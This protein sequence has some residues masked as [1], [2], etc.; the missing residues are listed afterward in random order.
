MIRRLL[1]SSAA[2]AP[3]LVAAAA[4]VTLPS[5]PAARAQDSSLRAERVVPFASGRAA[6]LKVKVG[7]V[8]VQSVEFSDRGRSGSGLLRATVPETATTLRGHFLVENPASDE[9]D[10]TVTLEFR[11]KAGK[12]IDRV[13][14]K[15]SWEGEAKPLD[16]DH[17]ILSYVVPMIA[18]VRITFE[19]RLS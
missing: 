6:P 10:V 1:S 9:W 13:V 5:A 19:A 12:V 15:G 11:D 3:L 2:F 7:P 16:V 17:V 8:N 14:K 4:I 18:D